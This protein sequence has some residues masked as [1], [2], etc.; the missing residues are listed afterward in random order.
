MNTKEAINRLRDI[1]RR[2]HLSI[3]TSNFMNA[4]QTI[5]ANKRPRSSWWFSQ[6]QRE[7][8][9][10][11]PYYAGEVKAAFELGRHERSKDAQLYRDLVSL[12]R[13]TPPTNADEHLAVWTQIERLKNK[14]GGSI[15]T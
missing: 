4:L 13:E 14:Y 12:I 9:P 6:M 15:P 3:E 5:A 10:D 2:K 11:N 8:T 7:E 1:V